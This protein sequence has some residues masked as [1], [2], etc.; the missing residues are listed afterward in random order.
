M[1]IRT[2]NGLRFP[3]G[4]IIL[5]CFTLIILIPFPFVASGMVAHAITLFMFI[6]LAIGWNLQGGYLGDLSFGH[7][8]FFGISAYTAALLVDYDL[9]NFAP[10]NILLGALL[11]AAFA[12]VIG[13]PFLRLKGFYFA[14]GTLGLSSLLS[15]VF[16]N[17][18]APITH[19]ATGVLV[20]PPKPYHIEPFYYAGLIIV[21][22][23][24]I[25]S[26]VVIRSRVGLA[27]NAIRDDQTAARAM[28]I[29]ITYY[30]ILGFAVSAFIIGIAGGFFPYYTNYI[31][32]DGVFATSLSFEMLVM[33]FLGGAAT[34]S[35]PIIGAVVLYFL[36]EIGRVYIQTGFYIL[37][38]IV[39]II[40]FIIMPSGIA[41]FIK[42]YS[43]KLKI[44]DVFKRKKQHGNIEGTEN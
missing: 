2:N 15:L 35:G 19:G 6:T 38:A 1:T 7:A 21:I 40:V 34:M 41:G 13:F 42:K 28:G 3:K 4:R 27:F 24:F 30:R 26:Y 11:A 16:K 23:S 18:L 10:L 29:N 44:Q 25:I 9:L 33:V 36:E 20:P 12:I 14:I 8:S 31:N 32:P 17:I 39:L 5:F 37:P 43:S 22:I